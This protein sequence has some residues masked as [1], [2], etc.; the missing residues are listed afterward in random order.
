MADQKRVYLT[1]SDERMEELKEWA[2]QE[3][4]HITNLAL[5]LIEQSIDRAKQSGDY[6]PARTRN[7]THNR[8]QINVLGLQ[9]LADQ[10]DIPSDRLLQV[11]KD[12]QLD[13]VNGS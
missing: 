5:R 12:I 1:L 6:K 3:G 8:T 4:R 13:V 7:Q 11:V 9:R 2:D 10:L